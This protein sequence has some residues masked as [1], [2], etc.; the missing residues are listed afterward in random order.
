MLSNGNFQHLSIVFKEANIVLSPDNSLPGQI[1]QALPLRLEIHYSPEFEK[2]NP[3]TQ[4]FIMLF[5]I[6]GVEADHIKIPAKRLLYAD[7]KAYEI[8][9]GKYGHKHDDMVMKAID[10][11]PKNALSRMRMDAL[12]KLMHKRK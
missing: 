6:N 11:L 12:K 8:M 4:E 1:A 2:L 9:L 7:K 10:I 5:I 3:F